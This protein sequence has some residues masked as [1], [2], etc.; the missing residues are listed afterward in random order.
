MTSWRYR[1]ALMVHRMLGI[2]MGTGGSSGFSYL[3]ATAHRHKIF[4]D[5]SNLSTYL[6]PRTIRPPLPM[7]IKTSMQFAYTNRASTPVVGGVGGR[8]LEGVGDDEERGGEGKSQ[9]G[10]SSSLESG[11]GKKRARS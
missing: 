1:H 10:E 7:G 6:V 11:S 9:D 3:R 2:K 8:S 5:F 4:S